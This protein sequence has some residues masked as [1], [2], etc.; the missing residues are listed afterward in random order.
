MRATVTALICLSMCAIATISAPIRT[1]RQLVQSKIYIL[2]LE[3]G[4][5]VKVTSNGTLRANGI[6]GEA[7]TMFSVD[8]IVLQDGTLRY[9][10]RYSSSTHGNLFWVLTDEGEIR[11]EKSS[12]SNDLF[13][14]KQV[15]GFGR[16]LRVHDYSTGSGAGASSAVQPECHVGFSDTTHPPSCYASHEAAETHFAFYPAS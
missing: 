10:L 16:A 15:V 3:A 5:Y 6:P 1:N 13:E 2:A 9:R 11:V 8:E 4:L 14:Q 7:G 12:G